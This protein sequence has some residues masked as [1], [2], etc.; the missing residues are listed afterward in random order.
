MPWPGVLQ[1]GN[2]CP[3]LAPAKMLIRASFGPRIRG[4]MQ[5]PSHTD[6][7]LVVFF[8]SDIMNFSLTIRLEERR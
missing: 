2:I 1:G 3:P 6:A 5:F 7:I 4:Y 8:P